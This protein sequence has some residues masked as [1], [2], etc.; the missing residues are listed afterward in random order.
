MPI[1]SVGRTSRRALKRARRAGV[2]LLE[3]LVVVA[4]VGILAGVAF[5]S[6]SSG[7][8]TLRLRS[9]ADA[10][11]G[12]FNAA[13]VR[14]DRRQQVVEVTILKS[15]RT[16]WLR[17]TEPGSE[18]KLELP[19]G[20]TVAAVFPALPRQDEAPRRFLLYPGGTPPRAGVELVNRKGARRI[21]RIDP[22]T[23]VPRVEP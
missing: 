5:P 4:L 20:I 15:E 9:A 8:E 10:V 11:A 18:R 21:V 16:L 22:V 19:E 1:L 13:L 12:F 6:I 14:A 2:T 17:S 3:M 7:V 23:G